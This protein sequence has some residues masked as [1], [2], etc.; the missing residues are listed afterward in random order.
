[1]TFAITP[2]TNYPKAS[3]SEFPKYLE[4]RGNGVALGDRGVRIVDL[5]GA[6]IAATRGVGENSHVVTVKRG[7]SDPDFANVLLLMQGDSL[8]NDRSGLHNVI[9]VNGNIAVSTVQTLFGNPTL[10]SLASGPF[11]GLSTQYGQS[12]IDANGGNQGGSA[13]FVLDSRDFSIEFW[14]Y[15]SSTPGGSYTQ[16]VITDAAT[17]SS[18]G[19]IPIHYGDIYV[20]GKYGLRIAYSAPNGV[21]L[22]IPTSVN[23]VRDQWNFVQIVRSGTSFKYAVNGVVIGSGTWS[24]SIERD[25]PSYTGQFKFITNQGIPTSRWQAQFRVSRVARPIAIP[26][27]PWPTF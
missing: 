14:E 13:G 7:G 2:K 27:G 8:T 3:A 5:V 26:T 24:G 10:F 22:E 15:I 19:Q 21:G 25:A 1:M 18:S 23:M 11:N 4:I 20:A 12:Y 16:S 17:V 9:N 6:G